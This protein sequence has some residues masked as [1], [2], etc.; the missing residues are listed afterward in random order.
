MPLTH[1]VQGVKTPYNKWIE[2][3][4]LGRHALCLRKGRAGDPTHLSLPGQA[5]RPRSPLIQA[6]VR[7]EARYEL[8]RCE[9]VH[10]KE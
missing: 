10:G 6:L 7:R 9:S 4:S 3:T 2:R 5:L 8:V 1:Q